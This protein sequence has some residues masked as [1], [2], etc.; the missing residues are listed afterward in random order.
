MPLYG[1]PPSPT[2]SISGP[3]PVDVGKRPPVSIGADLSITELY[4]LMLGIAADR[5]KV[6]VE[7]ENELADINNLFGNIR[8]WRSRRQTTLQMQLAAVAGLELEMYDCCPKS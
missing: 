2:R 7:F 5:A 8:T 1:R 3:A 6:T 4:S